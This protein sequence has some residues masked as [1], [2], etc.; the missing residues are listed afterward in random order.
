MLFYLYLI[1]CFLIGFLSGGIVIRHLIFRKWNSES[2]GEIIT[3][4]TENYISYDSE[5]AKE[6]LD[7]GKIKWVT[8]RVKTVKNS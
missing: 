5:E 3:N 6:K 1:S 7:S 8:F 4:G 2:Y